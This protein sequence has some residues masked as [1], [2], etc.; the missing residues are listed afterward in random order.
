MR[1][2]GGVPT[3]GLVPDPWDVPPCLSPSPVIADSA[4]Y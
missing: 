1:G 2:K 4:V 3:G